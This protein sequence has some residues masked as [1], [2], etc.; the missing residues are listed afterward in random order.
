MGK[1]D[2]N[3]E[4]KGNVINETERECIKERSFKVLATTGELAAQVSQTVE[5]SDENHEGAGE[6]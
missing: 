4:I 3:K 5:P 1:K 6:N 2:T